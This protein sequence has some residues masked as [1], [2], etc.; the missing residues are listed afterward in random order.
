MDGGFIRPVLRIPN[1]SRYR[2]C[3]DRHA[4][5]GT[6]YES[7]V[8]QQVSLGSVARIDK[9]GSWEKKQ[10]STGCPLPARPDPSPPKPAKVALL[11]MRQLWVG[12]SADFVKLRQATPPVQRD[13]SHFKAGEKLFLIQRKVKCT[14][15]FARVARF[16]V[17]T[18]CT[19]HICHGSGLF[20]A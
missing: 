16:G 4:C 7:A 18:F 2:T 3:A 13:Y 20:P 14:Y 5:R 8:S 9:E 12:N 17:A 11:P 15:L 1:T 10:P 19:L 6:L